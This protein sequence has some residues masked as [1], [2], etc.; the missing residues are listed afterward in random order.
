VARLTSIAKKDVM[1]KLLDLHINPDYESF[2]IKDEGDNISASAL[3][4]QVIR[5]NE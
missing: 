1:L 5:P 4:D 2:I 3:I